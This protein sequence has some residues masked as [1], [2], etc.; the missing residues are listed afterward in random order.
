MGADIASPPLATH[1][2]A[3]DA[4][5]KVIHELR[6]AMATDPHWGSF[7]LPLA[8]WR[9]GDSGRSPIL[10]KHTT[11]KWE[12]TWHRQRILNVLR[13]LRAVAV[14]LHTSYFASAVQANQGQSYATNRRIYNELTEGGP[15]M[16]EDATRA[17][18]DVVAVLT[19]KLGKHV[20]LETLGF[21]PDSNETRA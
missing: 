20:S 16:C 6:C 5:I 17:L 1:R 15:C 18:P 11:L 19:A 12:N 7:S 9:L 8:S 13:A 2:E 21:E 3:Y 4:A 10:V 14:M